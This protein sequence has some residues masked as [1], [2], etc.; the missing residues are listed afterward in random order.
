MDAATDCL[1]QRS[2]RKSF[3]DSSLIVIAHRLSTIGDF[4]KVVVLDGGR[5]K[6]LGTPLEL[7]NKNGVFR[8]MCTDSSQGEKEKLMKSILGDSS[9]EI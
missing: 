9:E 7:W 6:E 3:P 4:D 2:I 8:A 5:V 1:V